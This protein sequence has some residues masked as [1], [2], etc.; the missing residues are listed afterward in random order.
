MPCAQGARARGT[1]SRGTAGPNQASSQRGWGR[2]ATGGFERRPPLFSS[3]RKGRGPLRPV[4]AAAVVS[5]A[6]LGATV[7]AAGHQ[8]Q[9]ASGSLALA[10][11]LQEMA[12]RH[13]IVFKGIEK[14]RGAPLRAAEGDVGERLK[15]LLSDFNYVMF[16]S[17]G[18]GIELVITS[19]LA[20]AEVSHRAV[21]ESAER[22]A[23]RG[24]EVAVVGTG[25]GR[26][27]SSYGMRWH[28][29]LGRRMMHRGIDFQAPQGAP[30]YAAAE[31]VVVEAGRRGAY[32]KC[33]VILHDSGYQTLYAH[34]SGFAD[35]IHSGA[36]VRQGQ[37]VGY[38]GSTGRS[39]GPHLHFE[40]RVGGTQVDPASVS[41][42]A[43]NGVFA[44]F[45][46]L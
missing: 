30:V 19:R 16:R 24:A 23:P 11:Q 40:V 44:G 9:A 36:W 20:R 27:S 8:Q 42:P 15:V 22:T 45:R 6:V 31:G 1:R 29:I 33:V 10:E 25:G 32:G 2:K 12:A 35:G 4:V 14:T 39:T 46:R 38:V 28:P 3:G 13:G 17:S 34:V 43:D 37:L 5:L 18:G 41:L 21:S 7:P 26:I